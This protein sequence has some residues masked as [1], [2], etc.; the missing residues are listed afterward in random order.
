[1]NNTVPQARAAIAA[2][3]ESSRQPNNTTICTCPNGDGWLAW[4]CPTHPSLAVTVPNEVT[5]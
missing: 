5:P 1:M 2:A 4:P 3:L